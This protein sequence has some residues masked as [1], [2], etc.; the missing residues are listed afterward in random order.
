MIR[1]IDISEHNGNVDME[2][3][4]SDGIEFAILRLGYGKNQNQIDKKF[5]VNYENAIKNNIPVGIYLYSY[6]TNIDDAEKEAELVLNNIKGLKIEY[7]IFIDMEDADEYKAKRNVTNETC[8]NICEKFCLEIESAGYYTGIYANLDWL[9]N[10]IN[11]SKLNRFDKWIAQW[12]DK[13]TYKSKYGM[14]QYTSQGQ[15]N[16]ISGNV[17]LNYAI[18]DYLEIIRNANLN[19]LNDSKNNNDIYYIVKDGDN[20]S[21][22]ASKY[23]TTWQSIYELNKEQIGNNPNL[24]HTG[25][26]LRI[27]E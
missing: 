2:K 13:C 19:H 10:K 16:G 18:Y 26:K 4:K 12:N 24:I 21:K 7:P 17:D 22:I 9:N 14:W 8:I 15:I 6:A 1:G 20:L 27:K 3:L 25:L 11:S 5:K 23:N